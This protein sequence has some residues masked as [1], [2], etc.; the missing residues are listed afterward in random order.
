MSNGFPSVGTSASN[1]RVMATAKRTPA[2]PPAID[3]TI[4]STSNCRTSC[5]RDAHTSRH[6][7]VEY[8]SA[9]N[10]IAGKILWTAAA[11]EYAPTWRLRFRF[12]R[13]TLRGL[14]VVQTN[15]APNGSE[16]TW[17]IHEFRI[18]DGERELL[19][20]AGWRLTAQPYPWAIQDAFDNS[21]VTFWLCGETLKP[22]QFA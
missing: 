9:S 20:A 3:N 2:T 8:Q 17:S 13:Q 16:D 7:L 21:L 4:L 22:G 18:Y 14:R 12:P 1:P 5:P 10:Q 11:P 15:R 19:R 6:I